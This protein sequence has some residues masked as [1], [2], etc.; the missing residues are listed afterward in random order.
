M[1]SYRPVIVESPF[2]ATS[3]ADLER[4]KQYLTA[5]MR[6]CLMNHDD[7]PFASHALYTIPLDDN[8]V[9]EREMGIRAGFA[10]G[11]FA[12]ACV[13]YTDYGIS[14]GMKQGIEHALAIYIEVEYRELY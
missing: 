11:Q 2:K 6:D 13:V 9:T 14:E 12:D 4:N 10:W 7:A 8:D 5:C 3:A 1:K